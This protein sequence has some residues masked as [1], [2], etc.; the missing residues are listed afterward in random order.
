MSRTALVIGGGIAGPATAMAL[1]KAGIEAVIYEAH[2]A[3]ADGA[4][5]FLTLGSNGI[6]A[7]KAIGAEQRATSTGFATPQITLCSSKGK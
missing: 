7:L 5:V 1:Q 2:A 4:G 3:G 6:A